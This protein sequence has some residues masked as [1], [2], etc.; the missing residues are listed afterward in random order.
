MSE[1]QRTRVAT[2]TALQE[3][4]ALNEFY[5]NRTLLLA[6]ENQQLRDQLAVAPTPVNVADEPAGQ[7]EV[8]TNG[9]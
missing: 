1:P 3:A 5:R 9:D 4:L 2:T 8:S 7:S 6:H